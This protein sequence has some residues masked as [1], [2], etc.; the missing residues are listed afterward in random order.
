M[1]LRARVAVPLIVLATAAALLVPA[2]AQA[3]T[4]VGQ[5]FAPDSPGSCGGGNLEVVQ[6]SST[7]ASY[8]APAAGVLTSWSFLPVASGLTTT[9]T[10]RVFRPHAD[11]AQFTVVA[12]AGPLQTFAPGSGLQSFPTRVPVQAGDLIGINA[13]AGTC[14]STS[15][16]G[17]VVRYRNFSAMPVTAPGATATYGLAPVFETLDIA[18]SWEPDADGDGYGD[19]SQDGCPQLA[20]THGTCIPD[21]TITK[22]PKK[23]AHG[24]SSKLKFTSTIPGSTFVCKLDKKKAKQCT[25]PA[26]YRCL[27]PG[28][29]RFSV[30]ATN[31][32]GQ[33][34]PTPAQAKFKVS[35]KRHG[36]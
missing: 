12:D 28:K 9:L 29:H 20:Q 1:N 21:T 16:A 33:P 36:C 27:K 18:A 17:N 13:T 31:P 4:T 8:A 23:G 7:T 11:P 19:E 14:A 2:P 3:A 10:L 25:S 32:V 5:T 34:D 24:A 35:A 26:K 6:T 30:F 22:T 15:S